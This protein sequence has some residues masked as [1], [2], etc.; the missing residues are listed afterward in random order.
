MT[1]N[2]HDRAGEALVGAAAA[3]QAVHATYDTLLD[4]ALSKDEFLYE[5]LFMGAA[6]AMYIRD[7]PIPLRWLEFE[8]RGL[9]VISEEQPND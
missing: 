5:A 9:I 2:T 1:E 7:V 6:H 4:P 3:M 8:L